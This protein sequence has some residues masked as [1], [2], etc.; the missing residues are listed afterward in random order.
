[1]ADS[2]TLLWTIGK[3]DERL[4]GEAPGDLLAI[5][6]RGHPL[7]VVRFGK[8]RRRSKTEQFRR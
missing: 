5:E 4:R 6:S 2:Q 8:C 7:R 3:A 1:M